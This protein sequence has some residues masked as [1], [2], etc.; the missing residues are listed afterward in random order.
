MVHNAT[1]LMSAGNG[2]EIVQIEDMLKF[3]LLR[4]GILSTLLFFGCSQ[5]RE[6]NEKQTLQSE[7]DIFFKS[8]DTLRLTIDL[9]SEEGYFRVFDNKIA[10]IHSELHEVL[11]FDESGEFLEKKLGMG[12][13]PFQAHGPLWY[14][15][16]FL[17]GRHLFLGST[18]VFKT[19]EANLSEIID[20]KPFSWINRSPPYHGKD[21][22]K[23][24]M[25]D[26]IYRDFPMTD[27]QWIPVTNANKALI[28]VHIA[29]FVHPTMNSK[30]V[31]N[32]YFEESFTV[33]VVD[34]KSGVLERVIRKH[35]AIFKEKKWLFGYDFTYRDSDSLYVYVSD[36]ASHM[37]DVFDAGSFEYI[38]TFG[39]PGKYFNARYD[40]YD[41]KEDF[42]SSYK[43]FDK[44]ILGYSHYGHLYKDGE[45][46][47]LFRSYH[48][49]GREPWGLQIYQSRKLIMDTK[50]PFRFNVIGKIGEF[51]Y[52]DGLRDE[53]NNTLA[54]YR[55]KIEVS[56]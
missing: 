16:E 25:Y 19:F 2:V 44:T 22:S 8:I 15:G 7:A 6:N 51:Y 17:D 9:F 32:G 14:H 3:T 48:V 12:S 31:F 26:L 41:T 50:V 1:L 4:V 36:R 45:S 53:E 52:A 49:K 33:G 46:N 23:P 54:I 28:P 13:S 27:S 40:L 37:I 55:F 30:E 39:E 20:K 42:V 5:K 47:L 11:L 38:S 43:L 29:S 10:Y 24:S 18:Y 56:D 21:L 35:P 34:L